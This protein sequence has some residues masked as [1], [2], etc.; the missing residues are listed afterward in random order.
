MGVMSCGAL[1]TAGCGTDSEDVGFE[2]PFE[3]VLFGI[4]GRFDTQSP[5]GLPPFQPGSFP[6]LWTTD[7]VYKTVLGYSDPQVEA[8]RADAV[9]FLKRRFGLDPDDASLQG[10][11]AFSVFYAD[12]R[13]NYRAYT[14][15]G[16][17]VPSDGYPVH[18]GGFGLIVTSSAGVSLGG[19]FA[20][21]PAQ[22]GTLLTLGDYVVDTGSEKLVIE[23]GT[24]RPFAFTPAGLAAIEC[25]VTSPRFGKGVS[26]VVSNFVPVDEQGTYQIRGMNR[27]SF[28]P[29]T[30]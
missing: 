22:A 29:T 2:A 10:K 21:A 28:A 19:D 30:P 27:M 3:Q 24:I 26:Q 12:P 9:A 16:M 15:P 1:V 14:L 20:G 23:Y 11:V 7:Y 8:R 13:W 6:G 5:P 4:D 18:D 17:D 25:E